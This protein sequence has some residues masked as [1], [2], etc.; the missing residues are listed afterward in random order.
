MEV[1]GGGNYIKISNDKAIYR[2]W[3]EPGTKSEVPTFQTK[4]KRAGLDNE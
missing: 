1:K 4:N 3:G 2:V